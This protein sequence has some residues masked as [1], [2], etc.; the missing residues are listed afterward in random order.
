MTAVESNTETEGRGR[1][2]YFWNYTI[3]GV[4]HITLALYYGVLPS[5]LHLSFRYFSGWEL[6][7]ML[8]GILGGLLGLGLLFRY[9]WMAVAIMV[10][11]FLGL[12][13]F[14]PINA[15]HIW[16]S[17]P[18]WHFRPSPKVLGLLLEM[19]LLA[20]P[21]F[22]IRRRLGLLPPAIATLA[23]VWTA[24]V[25]IHA[26]QIARQELQPIGHRIVNAWFDPS[27][28]ARVD[29]SVVLKPLVQGSV[30]IEVL[31]GRWNFRVRRQPDGTWSF[32]D[33]KERPPRFWPDAEPKPPPSGPGVMPPP[34]DMTQAELRNVL[35]AAGLKQE[36][37][38]TARS[39]E[40]V[41]RHMRPGVAGTAALPAGAGQL[42]VLD[43]GYIV[44]MLNGQTIP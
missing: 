38:E 11:A 8:Q 26:A 41:P 1:P 13:V 16:V 35:L 39:L 30:G 3:A 22:P 19:W 40:K 20:A 24:A 12:A 21:A 25:H 4:L 32:Y 31:P 27:A 9:R 7:S 28:V 2:P 23:C 42:R 29:T 36:V 18:R 6:L 5:F 34:P 15:P 17:L 37:A 14:N 10:L 33:I 43:E 44:V